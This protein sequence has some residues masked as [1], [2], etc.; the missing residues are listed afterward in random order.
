MQN[1]YR[2]RRL[3]QSA[4]LRDLL[5]ETSLKKEDLVQPYFVLEHEDLEHSKPITSMSGQ[6][7]L[8]ISALLRRVEKAVDSGLKAVILFGIPEIKDERASQAYDENG[9]IQMA[10]RELK[11]KFSNLI[12]ITDVCMCEY[13]SHGHC[14][15][16]ENSYVQ[17][18]A[19]LPVLAEIAVSHA[20]AGADMVA[21]SD[22]MDGRVGEI[23]E[24]LDVNGFSETPIMSYAVKYASSFYGPFR[25]AANSSPGFGD[26]K[27]YQMDPANSR[28]AL[29]EAR[30]DIR[31]GADILMVKP[32]LPY[33]DVLSSL[34][35]NFDLPLAA[36]HVSG[37][38]SLIKAA[39]QMGWIDETAVALEA[40]TSI[41]RAGASLVLS[42]FAEDVLDILNA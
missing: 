40:L 18:D 20:R 9:I 37:E 1:F 25:E 19:T 3:R 23:R 13:T 10:V 32:A 16:V 31:E 5:R 11:E 42:Y 2:G 29:R 6:D 35:E 22:M 33:L 30:A 7:Q 15:I 36:Y 24:T 26:R 27:T 34:R 28:E 17:N 4:T 38:Y 14:G 39:G 8:A 12:V 41:K 21:P